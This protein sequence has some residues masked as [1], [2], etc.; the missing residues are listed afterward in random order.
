MGIAVGI[1]IIS[2]SYPMVLDHL[3][4]KILYK[5]CFIP[6]KSLSYFIPNIL[7]IAYWR[8]DSFKQWQFM[9]IKCIFNVMYTILL[10]FMFGLVLFYSYWFVF[11][12]SVKKCSFNCIAKVYRN[13]EYALKQISIHKTIII[14]CRTTQDWRDLWGITDSKKSVPRQRCPWPWPPQR[15]GVWPR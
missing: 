15:E 9:H 2:T 11:Y 10:I 4:N 3:K 8:T 14:C 13:D 12:C 5:W 7:Q 1:L 6:L